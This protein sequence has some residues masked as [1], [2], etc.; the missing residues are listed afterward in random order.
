MYGYEYLAAHC[1]NP[2]CAQVLLLHCRGPE[3]P[4]R[5]GPATTLENF[6]IDVTCRLCGTTLPYRAEDIHM[7]MGLKP[8]PDFKPHPSLRF[9]TNL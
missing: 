1:K 6:V 9:V 8:E 5:G 2:G 4:Y 3:H 7:V